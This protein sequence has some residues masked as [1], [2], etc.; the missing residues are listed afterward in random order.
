MS[1]LPAVSSCTHSHVFHPF[2][3][4]LPLWKKVS[5]IAIPVLALA[6]WAYSRGFF[7]TRSVVSQPKLFGVEIPKSPEAKA[8][9][10][11]TE[12]RITPSINNLTFKEAVKPKNQS[13][14]FIAEL[15][16]REKEML[17]EQ[18]QHGSWDSEEVRPQAKKTMQI[19]YVLAYLTLDEKPNLFDENYYAGPVI[20]DCL[21]L[22]HVIRSSGII[23]TSEDKTITYLGG[24]NIDSD[25]LTPEIRTLYN[26]LITKL[27][28]VNFEGFKLDDIHG[29][30]SCPLT[31]LDKDLITPKMRL[32]LNT[33]LVESGLTV[34][35]LPVY[36]GEFPITTERMS[37]WVMKG[38]HDGKPFFAIKMQHKTSKSK[39][40]VFLAPA[41]KYRLHTWTQWVLEGQEGARVPSFFIKDDIQLLFTENGKTDNSLG[42]L[43]NL[44]NI[45]KD[46]QGFD[47][48]NRLWEIMGR[49]IEKE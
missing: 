31:P 15:L 2:C 28:G 21:S 16:E 26:E 49:P 40:V 39:H 19:A 9:F 36:R 1:Y 10:K 48:H 23:E 27:G 42:N 17:L 43:T 34:D 47:A 8:A 4:S 38:I 45:I 25:A 20:R 30:Y 41:D 13:I 29:T 37:N 7:N 22:Y 33:L 3:F 44:L 35:T 32:A 18:L 46:G 6:L 12:W 11:M 5:T 24:H 14:R